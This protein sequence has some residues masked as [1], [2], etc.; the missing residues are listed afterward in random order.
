MANTVKLPGFCDV[1]VHFRQPG[2]EYKETIK[3][4]SMAAARGGYT[5]V[6][7]MPNL[8][9]VPDTFEHLKLQLDAIES[10]GLID[11]L[12]YGSIT[13]GE[14]GEALSD[15]DAMADDAVSFSDDGHGVDSD[16]LMRA[17][18]KKAA[19]LGKI[20]TA[21]CEDK[22]APAPDSEWLEVERNIKLAK[23]TGC[24]LHICHV[25]TKQSV[26]YVRQAKAEGIDVTAE[27]APH[28]LLFD[29]SMIEDSG[30]F[31]MNPPIGSAGDREALIE[32]VIDGTIDMIATDH[33]PHSAEEK[34]RGF[35]DS[36]SGIVGLETAF[37]VLYTGLVKTNI[38]SLDRLLE[39]MVYAPRKRFNI[40]LSDE[41]YSIWDLDEEYV[42]DTKEFLS[43]GKS[44]PFE[45]R[46]VFGRCLKTVYKGAIVWQR[47]QI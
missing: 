30:R 27:T 26:E 9:P 32:A 1:H 45:N 31:K 15:M 33:A 24:G 34:A 18:M 47:E 36:L 16:D 38:I 6:C 21:H 42:I 25:S 23:E 8:N 11:V 7:T 28:Y 40:A 46:R 10:D 14:K 2:F 17:A 19:S 44:T 12:P 39:L 20:L 3:T 43:K 13:V 29:K 5:A 22:S 4:G 35:K 37:P 41:D